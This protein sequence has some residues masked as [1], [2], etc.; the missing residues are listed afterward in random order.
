MATNPF[1]KISATAWSTLRSRAAA[2]PTVKLTPDSVAALMKLA[3]A[4]S[5][6]K[7]VVKP[8]RLLG[9]VDNDGNLTDRGNKWRIDES[10]DEACQQIMDDVYPEELRTLINEHG[11]PDRKMVKTWFQQQ[12]FG[13]SNA[14]LMAATYVMVASKQLPGTPGTNPTKAKKKK[15][16]KTKPPSKSPEPQATEKA[17]DGGSRE[18]TTAPGLPAGRPTVHL[19]VQVHIPADA[20]PEQIDLIFSSMARHLYAA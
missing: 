5:A 10:F 9:L 19:N 4:Q 20:T 11:R 6:E 15:S 8:M 13:E 18:S 7:N 17:L 16:P 14:R 3:N 12:G 1:P 2:S